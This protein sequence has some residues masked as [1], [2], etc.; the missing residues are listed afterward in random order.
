MSPLISMTAGPRVLSTVASFLTLIW[1]KFFFRGRQTKLQQFTHWLFL[2]SKG[3]NKMF[4]VA[5]ML[6]FYWFIEEAAIQD[7]R[8][9]QQLFGTLGAPCTKFVPGRRGRSLSPA[10][11]SL[12]QDPSR[13]V[14]NQQ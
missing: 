12:I 14:L 1:R 8:T 9:S 11:P 2:P 4:A 3:T 6:D 5:K 13:D 7:L 10:A